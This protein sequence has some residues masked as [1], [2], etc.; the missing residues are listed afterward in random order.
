MYIP[1]N[2]GKE[3]LVYCYDIN[4]LFLSVMA[5]YPMLIGKATYF[6]GDI[7]KYNSDAFGFFI[8][9]LQHLKI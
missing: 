7:R 1:T 4:S 9:E 8:V 3:E 2:S 6:E 5:E